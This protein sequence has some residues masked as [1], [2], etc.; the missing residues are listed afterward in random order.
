MY[1]WR[2]MLT[3]SDSPAVGCSPAIRRR[4]P[5]RVFHTTHAVAGTINRAS[6]VNSET[7]LMKPRTNPARS[8][9]KKIPSLSILP[10]QSGV[11][12]PK[13]LPPASTGQ[14]NLP[15]AGDVGRLGGVVPDLAAEEA[16]QPRRH[17]V[18][19][20]A[21]HDVVDAEAD[22]GDGVHQPA[23]CTAD[24]PGQESRPRAP[25]QG[26]PGARTRCRRSSCPRGRC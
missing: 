16:H 5:N 23:Q 8:E 20:D 13:K 21:R 24:H 6:R 7:P 25:L 22:R 4:S 2:M 9:T 10:S 14:V 11:S 17:D 3:P 15:S 12:A 19:G 26:A 18:D 1:F